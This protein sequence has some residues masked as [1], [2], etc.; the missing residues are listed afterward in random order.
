M[1]VNSARV[2]GGIPPTPLQDTWL[3]ARSPVAPVNLPEESVEQPVLGQKWPDHDGGA[4]REDVSPK[5]KV[6]PVEGIVGEPLAI[7]TPGHI[8]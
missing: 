7:R 6:N 1:L 5:F 3:E 2:A 8:V 4:S